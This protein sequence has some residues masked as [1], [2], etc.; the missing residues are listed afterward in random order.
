MMGRFLRKFWGYIVLAVVIV[1][2]AEHLLG[3]TVLAVLSLLAL[4]YFLVQAPLWCMAANRDG[5]WCRNNSHGL[6]IG[7]N[8]VRQHKW[9][10]MRD[11]FVTRKWQKIIKNLTAS[12][13]TIL[14][15]V[16]S[17]LSLISFVAALVAHV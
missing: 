9:Q 13:A 15:T 5:T 17:L 10:R 12:P 14:G 7:C 3:A 6:L 2:W 4:V 8:Q 16:G 11:I 1:G